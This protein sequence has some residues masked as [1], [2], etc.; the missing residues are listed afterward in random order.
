MSD[1]EEALPTPSPSKTRAGFLTAFGLASVVG[2][3]AMPILAGPPNEEAVSQWGRFIGRFHPVVLH[4]PIGM[5]T[6]VILME[7][8]KLFRKDKGSSTL[9]PAFFTAVSAV[10]AV[11]TGFLFYQSGGYEGELV[12]SHLWWGIGFAC[13]ETSSSP[14]FCWLNRRIEPAAN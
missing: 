12:E 1:Q 9:V 7:F 10:V 13:H 5:L 3:L 4:L 11:I 6:L 14:A 8:G 2:I